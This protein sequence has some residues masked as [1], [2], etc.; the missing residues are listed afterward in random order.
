MKSLV[1]ICA[2][3]TP[4]TA[5]A[6][7]RGAKPVVEAAAE[8]SMPA[9][10]LFRLVPGKTEAF[11][12][13]VAIWDQV[14]AAGGQPKS[15]LYLHEDGEGWDVM[16]YK[17]PRPKPTTAQDAAMSAKIREL[18]LTTGPLYFIGLRELMADHAHLVMKGPMLS[19]DWVKELDTQRAE[20]KAGK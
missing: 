17:P 18:G 5:N 2:L 19:E 11:I 3:L 14:S 20:P 8:M 12:R 10:E 13:S 4:L 6:Q 15:Q 7:G 9:F 1:L 16:L